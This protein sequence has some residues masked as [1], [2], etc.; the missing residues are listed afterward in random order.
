[1]PHNTPNEAAPSKPKRAMRSRFKAQ[2]KAGM[3]LEERDHKLLTDLFLHRLMSRSQLERLYFTS[4]SRCNVRL[5]QLFDHDLVSRYYLPLAP[6]GAQCLYTLGEAGILPVSRRLEWEI[7]EVKRQTK[8]HK[9]P[10]FL[11]HTLA[12][13]ETRLAFREA[14]AVSPTWKLDRWI[15]EIQCR[16][17]YDIRGT[18]DTW[19]REVF[20]PDGFV[21][22]QNRQ[23]RQKADYFF[24]IDRGHTSSSKFADKLDTYTRYLESGLFS[25]MF[26]QSAFRTLVITTGPLRLKNL[27][28]LVEGKGSRLFCFTT[29]DELEEQGALA[30]IWRFAFEKAPRSLMEAMS[31]IG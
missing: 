18:G 12:I 27:R 16:H 17:D 15:P 31:N 13:N 3:R 21:R 4:A 10:Q 6:Y 23:T 22:V 25:Q 5:R 30:P 26:G 7:D 19:Q 14:L 2:I 9:T 20:K 29:F 11:E 8:R 24:E 1:M 28:A